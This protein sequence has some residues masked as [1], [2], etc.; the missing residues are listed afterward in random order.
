MRK[1]EDG[2]YT[3]LVDGHEKVVTEDSLY[4]LASQAHGAGTKFEEASKLRKDSEGA[5]G[6]AVDA[7]RAEERQGFAQCLAAAQTGN[8][9]AYDHLLTLMGYDEPQRKEAMTEFHQLHSG[10]TAQGEEGDTPQTAAAVAAA[11]SEGGTTP[12][13]AAGIR[14]LLEAV[15]AEG[16]NAGEVARLLTHVRTGRRDAA[17]DGIYAE[18]GTEL[19]ND[20]ILGTIRKDGGPKAEKLLALAKTFVK[21]RLRSGDK[22]GPELRAAVIKEVREHAEAFGAGQ[23]P[24]TQTGLGLAPSISPAVTQSKTPVKPESPISSDY[25]RN[26]TARLASFVA[27][28]EPSGG[29]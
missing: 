2:T 27:H 4:D 24:A 16:M 25:A 6:T 21:D 8:M 13:E 20:S 1:N 5:V 26:V 11:A 18:V 7:A 14:A 19:D 23:E 22:Y 12:Q 29:E 9:G 3:L 10:K 28:G 17:W 15:E